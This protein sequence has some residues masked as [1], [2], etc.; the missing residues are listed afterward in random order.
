M[1]LFDYWICIVTA[2]SLRTWIRQKRFCNKI[3]LGNC[4]QLNFIVL[5]NFQTERDPWD[6]VV[7][8]SSL[9][10]EGNSEAKII[11]SKGS[12]ATWEKFFFKWNCSVDSTSWQNSTSSWKDQMK[13][14]CCTI[15]FSPCILEKPTVFS[16][17]KCKC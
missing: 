15:F 7:R 4:L 1:F 12:I 3:F 2:W 11:K 5:Q 17:E 10:L 9:P 13:I 16:V 14:M 6:H 8:L